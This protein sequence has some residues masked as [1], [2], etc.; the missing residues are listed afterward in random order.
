VQTPRRKAANN[1]GRDDFGFVVALIDDL[2]GTAVADPKRVYVT[3]ISN[4]AYFSHHLACRYSDKI[5]AVAPVA[6]T[7]ITALAATAKPTRPVPI[8]YI[9]G[10][11]D[12]FIGMDGVDFLS[13]RKSSLSAKEMV[14]WWV[15]QNGCTDSAEREVLPRGKD[16]MAVE[17]TTY[18]GKAPVVFY[19]I[20]GGGHT[21]PGG[22]PFQPEVLLG[23]VCRSLDA[24]EVMWEF[25]SKHSLP[26]EAKQESPSKH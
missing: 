24:S 10:T 25:F 21:W 11:D 16:G 12:K 8:L 13:H 1:K 15:K 23:K 22:S 2:V 5:A 20:T 26:A 9:H 3:G 14:A 19:S 18:R 17:R 7:M 4:G 6:G